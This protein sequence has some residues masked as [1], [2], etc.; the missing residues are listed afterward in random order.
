MTSASSTEGFTLAEAL[1]VLALIGILALAAVPVLGSR[2]ATKLDMAAVEVGNAL[3]FAVNEASRTGRYVLVDASVPGRLAVVKS[4]ASGANLG[5]ISDPFNKR[6]LELD[7]SA[8]AWSGLAM[9]ASFFQ[10]GTAYQQLLIGPALQLQVF[11]GG[12][13]RGPLQSGSGIALTLGSMTS[14]VEIAELT[15]R[16]R[17]P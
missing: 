7:T 15:G 12:T 16:V 10:S 1:T 2:D 17:I 3:R 11:D 8:P 14:T 5:A 4:D 6:A 13:N 9:A